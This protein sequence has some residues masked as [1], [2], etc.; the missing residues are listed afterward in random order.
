[1]RHC[2][3][4]TQW[5]RAFVAAMMVVVAGAAFAHSKQEVTVPNE[6]AVLA[7]P[8]DVVS[9]AFDAPM[10]ITVIRLTSEAGE[11]FELERSDDMQPVTDF[12]A[13]PPV[14]PTGRY[15]VEWRG[16]SADGHAMKGRFSFEVAR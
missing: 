4:R 7:S 9:I 10:R 15:T 3:N 2:D 8:P 13:T 5:A 6:G 14:L 11:T 1:M 16:L 12:R